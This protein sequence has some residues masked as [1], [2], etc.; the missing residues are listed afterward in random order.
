MG[1]NW[2][3]AGVTMGKVRIGHVSVHCSDTK[4]QPKLDKPIPNHQKR[5]ILAEQ[6][7]RK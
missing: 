5:S 6:L 2:E 3:M 7:G 1:C 4:A